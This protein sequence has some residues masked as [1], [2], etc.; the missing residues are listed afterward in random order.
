MHFPSIFRKKPRK[1]YSQ[2]QQIHVGK[3][4]S[5]EFFQNF[6]TYKKIT[7]I[8]IEKVRKITEKNTTFAVALINISK[9]NEFFL[10]L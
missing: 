7:C 4:P 8:H 3:N 6:L 1:S 5:N 9:I 10:V 2:S